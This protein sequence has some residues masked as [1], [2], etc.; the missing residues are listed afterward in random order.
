MQVNKVIFGAHAI[1]TNGAVMSR[2]GSNV[3]AGIARSF[4]VPVLVAC[5]THKFNDRAAVDSIVYNEL[6][7]WRTFQIIVIYSILIH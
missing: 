3:V 1:L 4:N 6:G 2:A 7:K 5:E